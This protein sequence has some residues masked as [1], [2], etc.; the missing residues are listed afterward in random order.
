MKY[1]YATY[2]AFIIKIL[3]KFIHY[4]IFSNDKGGLN[5]NVINCYKSNRGYDNTEVVIKQKVIL[6]KAWVN[7][8]NQANLDTT[9]ACHNLNNE[10]TISTI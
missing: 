3:N 6:F 8:C 7:K 9:I 10:M 4:L 5:N 1:D 2:S